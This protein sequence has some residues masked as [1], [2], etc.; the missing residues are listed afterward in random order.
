MPPAGSSDGNWKLLIVTPGSPLKA[1]KDTTLLRDTWSNIVPKAVKRRFEVD[2]VQ[3][4]L[5]LWS[6]KVAKSVNLAQKIR[7]WRAIKIYATYPD[8]SVIVK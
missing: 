2:I 1:L 4:K 6:K 3:S 8:R 5:G 7:Y